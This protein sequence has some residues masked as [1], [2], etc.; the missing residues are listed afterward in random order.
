MLYSLSIGIVLRIFEA[1]LRPD[2]IELRFVAKFGEVLVDLEL[3]L[4]KASDV[5]S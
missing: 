3:I 1:S 5:R 2:M 4:R